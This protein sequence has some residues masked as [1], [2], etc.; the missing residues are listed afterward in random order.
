MRTLLICH[1]A[2]DLDREGLV[3]WLAS[4]STVAGVVTIR[5]APTRLR[6]R[7]AREI[8]RVGVWRFADVLAFRAFY[9]LAHAAG[10]REWERRQLARLRTWFP[11]WPDAPEILVSSPNA[12]DAEAFIRDRAPDLVIARCKT[13]LKEQVFAIPRLGTFV[14][15]PGICPEYRNAHGCFW[16]LATGDRENVGMT[17]LRIDR[18][19]DTGPVFGYFRVDAD[20]AESHVVTQHRAV[21][22]HLD[23]IRD[24]L[25]DIESGAAVP[26]DT[27]GRRSATWG[28]PWLSAYLRMRRRSCITTSSTPAARTAAV[29]PA[30]TPR[31]TR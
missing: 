30:G 27:A 23:A 8:R 17:L 29:F 24:K 14:M 2:A 9:R 13:L 26:I 20:P 22:D 7:I 21:L 3:R 25:L 5:E 28:Q 18:G 10:D 12:P 16:A 1:E 31:S 11:A 6:K 19:V 4:F 15:H